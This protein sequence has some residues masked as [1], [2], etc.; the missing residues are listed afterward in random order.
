MVAKFHNSRHRPTSVA[1]VTVTE[2]DAGTKAERRDDAETLGGRMETR[3]E[4]LA[5]RD[6]ENSVQATREEA[7]KVGKATEVTKLTNKTSSSGNA[8]HKGRKLLDAKRKTAAARTAIGVTKR[9][10]KPAKDV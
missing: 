5:Q 2:P 4:P 8:R 10:E 9:E 1:A 6:N 3:R 7:E